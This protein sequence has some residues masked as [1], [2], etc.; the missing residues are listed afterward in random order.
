M[1]RKSPLKRSIDMVD[2]CD[3]ECGGTHRH[4]KESTAEIQCELRVKVENSVLQWL[5]VASANGA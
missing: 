3:L 4:I 5:R 2:A 1:C